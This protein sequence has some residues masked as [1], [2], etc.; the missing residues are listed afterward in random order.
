M[1]CALKGEEIEVSRLIVAAGSGAVAGVIGG[2]GVDLNKKAGVVKTTKE[3]LKTT[4]SSKR[5]ARYSAKIHEVYGNIA[6]GI[7]QTFAGGV[8]GNII[9][10][11][12]DIIM[13]FMK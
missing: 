3:L 6:K 8:F 11:S 9:N 1:E 13:G 12:P 4:V 10:K 2:K 5:I 7:G